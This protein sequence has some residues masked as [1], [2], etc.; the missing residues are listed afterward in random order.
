MSMTNG[1]GVELAKAMAELAGSV[2]KSAPMFSVPDMRATVRWYESIGFTV[3][4]R[5]EEGEELVF[6]RGPRKVSLWFFTDRVDELYA[7]LKSTDPQGAPPLQFD[8]E[9]YEPFYGARQFSVRDHNGL[10]LVFWHPEW[11]GAAAS[12]SAA[13]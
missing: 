2:R 8:E 13:S 12:P 3:A 11:L 7:L 1:R 4:D 10:A 9:L 5:Y 6:A